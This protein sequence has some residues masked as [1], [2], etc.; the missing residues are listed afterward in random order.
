MRNY[1]KIY[2]ITITI[3]V[4]TILTTIGLAQTQQSGTQSNQNTQN[5]TSDDR[6][7]LVEALRSGGIRAGAEIKGNYVENFDPSPDWLNYDIE[8]LTKESQALVIGVALNNKGI[9][10]KNGETLKTL[11]E[12]Q[13]EEV[14]K[15]NLVFGNTIKVALPGGKVTFDNGTT[16]E[17][18]TPGFAKM[19]N[20]KTYALYLSESYEGNDIY[21]LTGGSMGLFKIDAQNKKVYS[22]AADEKVVKKQVKDKDL[23]KFLKET[24][25][26][27]G[28]YPGP[29]EQ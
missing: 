21:S 27:A 22:H 17:V 12:F 1:D 16:A 11:Y 10:S 8:I 18:R 6:A 15:G 29:P 26:Q 7:A 14:L 28:R 13:I 25:K 2:T 4:A 20:G 9:L 3:I 19:T 5:N 24:R 23:K